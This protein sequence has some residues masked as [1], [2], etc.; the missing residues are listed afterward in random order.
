[1]SHINLSK[2]HGVNPGLENCFYCNEPKG[3]IL[4]GAIGRGSKMHKA[5]KSAGLELGRNGEAPNGL[6]MDYE[7]CHKCQEYMKQG[8]ILISVRGTDDE[9]ERRNPYR[10]GG[11]V[12]VKDELIERI[13]HPKELADAILEKRVAF[14]PDE[15]WDMIGLPRGGNNEVDATARGSDH[16]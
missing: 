8:V 3:V 10:T 4:Y 14:I 16:D 2:E 6:V 7:P 13:V 11:W 1:M 5:V 12:V 15:A 9:K